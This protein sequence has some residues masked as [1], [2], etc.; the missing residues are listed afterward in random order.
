MIEKLRKKIALIVFLAVALPLLVIVTFYTLSYSNNIVRANVQFIDRLFG[1]PNSVKN[2]SPEDKFALA[3]MN[4]VYYISINN[5]VIKN[6]SENVTAEIE[7]YALKIADSASESG[8]IGN[9][10]FKKRSRDFNGLNI[11][12]VESAN[13]I[14]KIK[15]VLASSILITVGSLI[16]IYF[17]AKKIARLIVKPVEDTFTKQIDFI[18]DASHELK[19]PL[20]VI[21]ANADVLETKVGKNKWLTYIQNETDNMGKLIS[22]LLLLTKIEN[23]D[24]LRTPEKFNMS[25]HVELIASSFE[26]VAFEKNVKFETKIQKDIIT[27]KFNK[28]DITHILSTLIDNAIKHTEKGNKVIIELKKIKDKIIIDVKNKG[29]E[30]PVSEREKIF[31]RFYRIDKARN[32]NEKRYGLG[33]AIA[34]VTV[35]NNNGHIKVDYKG[36]FT[37]FT[38]E[39]PE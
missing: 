38:V 2:T 32:R 30:I 18:S 35:L 1:E 14:N 26:S 20:A 33:L 37:I 27:N 17:L 6:A 12:I 31:E 23:V 24:K 7:E 25:D 28:D 13:E 5:K 16:F 15:L 39:L 36:G 10:I 21:Q 3:D 22:E 11:I 4:G 34:K 9:Y 29:D 8:V 19:T